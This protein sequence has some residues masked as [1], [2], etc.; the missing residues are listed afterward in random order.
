MKKILVFLGSLGVCLF[1]Q[2]G[3]IGYVDIKRIFDNYQKAKNIQES[4]KKEV[5]DEQKNMDK[6]QEDIKKMQED[7]EKKKNM[8]KP[9]EQAKRESE[10]RRKIQEFS[11]KWTEV[12]KKL[13][14][15]GKDLENQIL[16]EI[17]AVT[18]EYAKK[19]GYSIVLDSRLIFYGDNTCDISDEIIKILNSKK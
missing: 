7:Y 8:M 14:E 5:M 6:M 18:G 3:K 4:F 11:Q 1:A 15:K 19:N 13:D 9:E 17:K 12:S 10:I 2:T 16:E